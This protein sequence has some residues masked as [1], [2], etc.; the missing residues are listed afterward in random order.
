MEQ[1]PPL[2]GIRVLEFAG[3]APGMSHVK[4]MDL[5]LTVIIDNLYGR[6]L[7]RPLTCRIWRDSPSG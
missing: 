4:N 2:T 7:C 5:C 6:S 1:E 3:L